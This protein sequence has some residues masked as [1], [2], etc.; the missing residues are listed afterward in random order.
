MLQVSIFSF[1]CALPYLQVYPHV[2]AVC[3]CTSNNC[4]ISVEKQLEKA[5]PDAY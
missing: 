1:N 2:F 3:N 4:N 5:D